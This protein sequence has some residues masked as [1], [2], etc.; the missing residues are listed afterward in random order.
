MSK[1]VVKLDDR[2][3]KLIIYGV[4]KTYSPTIKMLEDYAAGRR[5]H[6]PADLLMAVM[7]EWLVIKTP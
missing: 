5:N 3:P 2:R 1:K 7:R 4:K 6:L